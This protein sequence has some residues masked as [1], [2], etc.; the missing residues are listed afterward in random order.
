MRSL[1][2]CCISNLNLHCPRVEIGSIHY[3]IEDLQKYIELGVKD[4]SLP[5]EGKI[6]YEWLKENG[7]NIKRSLF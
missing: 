2:N 5:S 3:K 4:F 6:I 1:V 7:E